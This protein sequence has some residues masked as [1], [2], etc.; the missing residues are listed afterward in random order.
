MIAAKINKPLSSV[1]YIT[2]LSRIVK[3]LII[4]CVCFVAFIPVA[5]ACGWMRTDHSI[6]FSGYRSGREL[7]RLPFIIGK[8]PSESAKNRQ[9]QE[10][11]NT[12]DDPYE[13]AEKR[14]KE[15][16]SIWQQAG[17]ARIRG[18]LNEVKVKLKDYLDQTG[19]EQDFEGYE[20]IRRQDHRNSAIDQLD[21]LT[22]LDQGS[23]SSDVLCYLNARCT[24]DQ[25]QS[26]DDVENFLRPIAN[27]RNLRDNVEFLRA[28]YNYKPGSYDTAA[29]MFKSL[30]VT[31]R[32]S[33]KR[34]AAL[35]M[36]ARSDMKLYDKS[37]IECGNTQK[38]GMPSDIW[39]PAGN[40][41][42]LLLSEYPHGRYSGDGRGWLAHIWYVSGNRSAA[43]AEYFRMLS[44][45]GD[46][47][48]QIEA[49]KSLGIIRNAATEKEMNQVESLIFN[50][51]EVALTYAY[52]EIAKH[53]H[54][55]F[56]DS[57]DRWDSE[58]TQR[59]KSNGNDLNRIAE[60]A[61][62]LI[63]RYPQVSKNSAFVLRLAMAKLEIGDYAIASRL[64]AQ[65][66]HSGLRGEELQRALWVK[67]VA[68]YHLRNYAS[69]KKLFTELL[70]FNPNEEIARG[71]RENL[72]LINEDSSD[73]SGAL[74]Q[75][76][77][78]NYQLDIAYFV[79]V[80][81]PPQ[82][83]AEFVRTHPESPKKDEL[84][85]GLG[86]RYLRI[87]K[88]DDARKAFYSVHT[89][90]RAGDEYQGRTENDYQARRRH[91]L[92]PKSPYLTKNEI[93]GVRTDWVMTDIQ[94]ANDLEALERKVKDAPSDVTKAEA[95]YQLASYQYQASDFLYYNPAAWRGDRYWNLDLFDEFGGYRS[96]DE[97]Q[98]LWQYFQLHEPVVHALN[99]YLQ[100]VDQYPYTHAAQD[101]LYTAAVCHERLSNYNGYWR[102][103]Y[104]NRHAGNRMV[105]FADVKRAYPHYRLP[106]GTSG[107]EPA[108][109]TVNGEYGW[110]LPPKPP[111]PQP[112]WK[113]RLNKFNT[114][115]VPMF[116]PVT[117][118]VA[119]IVKSLLG[120]FWKIIWWNLVIRF[121]GVLII[122][123]RKAV[124]VEKQF[125]KDLPHRL[126]SP[127]ALLGPA[128]LEEIRKN[129]SEL[130]QR[131]ITT[132]RFE[133][134]RP[135]FQELKWRLFHTRSGIVFAV[136]L[137][138][139]LPFAIL[140][141]CLLW[142][143]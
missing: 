37:L 68:D 51:P 57:G 12:N 27:E 128:R 82:Q 10:A 46:H 24:F 77:E 21:A 34:E 84:M 140:A 43:L 95:L 89:I 70:R 113:I 73:L 99:L 54:S 130:F 19:P 20:P 75:Y 87:G 111:V 5:F 137:M 109:R 100:I 108:T 138:T 72:A 78:L 61:E 39:Q 110:D 143:L 28:V 22:A 36:A 124:N 96:P 29:K 131:E 76:I 30:A 44:D 125:L 62:K 118:R 52:Y 134:V 55:S 31:Y 98:L 90:G 81:M 23:L 63:K 127:R 79:D 88:W 65:A 15:L 136:H 119:S 56:D 133:I 60:F 53:P 139:H 9:I 49:L 3:P 4:G 45:N 93:P 1:S 50:E 94:T 69:A 114:Y 91:T 126:R 6:R 123:W 103:V 71:A 26:I 18:D 11:L 141:V 13:A 132:G 7:G 59:K 97:P 104:E 42:N 14:T 105:S 142:M 2:R 135:K 117:V 107:W 17:G 16:D 40:D 58:W 101:A 80:L 86:I 115:I 120:I 48:E 112:K 92:N 74:E 41:F 129:H 64:A 67:G 8:S 32:N 121:I 33:E 66:I 47:A 102:N 106:R 83:L 122:L 38:T 25:S 116:K 85:Y 35:Y